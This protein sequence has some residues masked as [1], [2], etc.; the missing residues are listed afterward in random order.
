[1]FHFKLFSVV[2]RQHHRQT[3]VGPYRPWLLL[4]LLS[5]LLHLQ[6]DETCQPGCQVAENE[7]SPGVEGSRWCDSPTAAAQCWTDLSEKTTVLQKDFTVPNRNKM[8]C[9]AL[10]TLCAKCFLLL[11]LLL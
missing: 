5:S 4:D 7:G 10:A 2:S 3:I 1:M 11:L 9:V 6:T 8:R